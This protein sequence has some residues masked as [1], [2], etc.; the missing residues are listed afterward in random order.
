MLLQSKNVSFEEW[1]EGWILDKGKF[2]AVIINH[3]YD[4]ERPTG[5]HFKQ[6]AAT[7][8]ITI[9]IPYGLSMGGGRKNLRLQF[10]Q[11]TQVGA[12]AVIARSHWEKRMYAMHCPAGDAHVHVL[13]HPRFDVLLKHLNTAASPNELCDRIGARMV[14][15]WNSHFSFSPSYSQSLNFSTFDLIGPELFEFAKSYQDNFCLLWRPHPGLFPVLAREGILTYSEI[16]QLRQE[17]VHVGIVLDES[18]SHLP[19]FEISDALFT[20]VGSFLLEY[21]ATGKPILALHNPDGEPLNE[22]SSALV[23]HYAQA[24]SPEEVLQFIDDLA[25]GDHEL[26]DPTT[27]L[28]EH[29]PYMDGHA[30]ERVA[31]LLEKLT[32]KV[33]AT[34]H[35]VG[36]ET[37]SR[38]TNKP[39]RH[40]PKRVSNWGRNKPIGTY[41]THTPVLDKLIENLREIRIKKE[42]EPGW[43]KTLKRVVNTVQL[44]LGEAVKHQPV[45]I[46]LARY[47]RICIKK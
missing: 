32:A 1:R 46:S 36:E 45:L 30:G 13:G 23:R 16:D 25:T 7:I 14:V 10:A 24:S 11:R 35:A 15:L 42:F 47:L 9:Y 8:P 28:E 6:L 5:L 37:A 33:A 22:E 38:W 18:P 31:D 43:R 4:R 40:I 12:S 27:A 19:A 26:P 41:Q 21:L 2:D 39:Q 20:D 3:P 44:Y 29:L 17:L 34:D